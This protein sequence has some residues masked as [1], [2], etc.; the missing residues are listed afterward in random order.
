MSWFSGGIDWYCDN[1]R[2]YMNDQPGFSARS[3]HWRCTIC[4]ADNDVS[5]DNILD[6]DEVDLEDSLRKECPKCGGNMHELQGGR[7]NEWE[8]DVCDCIATEENGVMWFHK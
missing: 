2:T 8:C 1:C 6:E 4:G 5:S 3:G 7:S